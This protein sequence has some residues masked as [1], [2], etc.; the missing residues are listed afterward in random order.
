MNK[1]FFQKLMDGVR[2]TGISAII[3]LAP[4]ATFGVLGAW[5]VAVIWP[6][7]ASGSVITTSILAGLLLIYALRDRV[8]VRAYSRLSSHTFRT[9]KLN[10]GFSGLIDVLFYSWG[11]TDKRPRSPRRPKVIY[12][13]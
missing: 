13:G 5:G 11:S 8:A 9:G 1:T 6:H 7:H 10:L 4:C 2:W 12:Y 3:T